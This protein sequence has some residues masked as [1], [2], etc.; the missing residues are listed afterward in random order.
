MEDIWSLFSGVLG[1]AARVFLSAA[2]WIYILGRRPGYDWTTGRRSG[3][4]YRATWQLGRILLWSPLIAVALIL[5]YLVY[6]YRG[7]AL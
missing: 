1:L 7:S 3:R 5:I 6:F 2:E 4:T